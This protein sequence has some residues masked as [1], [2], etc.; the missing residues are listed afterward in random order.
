[1]TKIDWQDDQALFQLIQEE[2]YTAVVGDVMDRS[3]LV[4]Q[5]LPP[6]IRPLRSDMFLVGRAM[7]VLA[8]DLPVEETVRQE[9]DTP[10]GLML[11]AL[12]DLK[13]GE[14]Y[15]CVGS[16]PHYALWGELMSTRAAKLGSSGAVLEG[17]SRDT[18]G[19]LRLNFPTFSY[20]PYAQDQSVRG[21]VVDF[22]CGVSFRND[23]QV[24]TGD[25]VLGD[26]DG[27]VVVPSKH[28]KDVIERAL[29]K[30]RGENA[31]RAAIEDGVSAREAF[32]RYGVM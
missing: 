8:E 30:V 26:V 13:P 21:R 31:V 12:D 28:E 25:L 7:P 15:I 18:V 29:I 2:L 10:F 16:S 9:Q 32:D 6:E 11:E 5:F 14:V 19:I 17:Y 22:R 20:G 24:E 4:H 27:V 1:V 3:G 23:V